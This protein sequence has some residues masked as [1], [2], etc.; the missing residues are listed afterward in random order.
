MT[1]AVRTLSL[2]G[3]HA[4]RQPKG[5]ADTQSAPVVGTPTELCFSG[6]RAIEGAAARNITMTRKYPR[7]RGNFSLEA[8]AM[9]PPI[10]YSTLAPSESLKQCWMVSRICADDGA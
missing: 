2:S 9:K 1:H 3:H 4:R 5:I 8:N 10:G 6:T 7:P